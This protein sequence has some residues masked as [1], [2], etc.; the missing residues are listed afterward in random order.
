[1]GPWLFLALAI[2]LEVVGT[3]LLKLSDGFAQWRWGLLAM[4]CY[5]ACFVALAPALKIIPVGVVYAVW[6][7]VGIAAA[8]GI[9]LLL[10]GERL[11]ALQLLCIACILL[12][13]VGLNLSTRT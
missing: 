13:A 4:L 6:A 9:G 10:F 2:G 7:G 12:G 5:G 1:M 3:L 8:A 11:S